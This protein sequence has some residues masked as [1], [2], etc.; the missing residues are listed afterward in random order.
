MRRA[1]TTRPPLLISIIANVAVRYPLEELSLRPSPL[2]AV[3]AAMHPPSIRMLGLSVL[4]STIPALPLVGMRVACGFPSPAD[5]F[6]DEELDLTKR[7][8]TNP[9][10]TF[11]AEAEGDSMVGFGIHPG[12]TLVVDRSITARDGDIA[13]VLWDG[14][15]TVK[16]LRLRRHWVELISGNEQLAPIRVTDGVELQVWGVVTW[17]FRKHW[18]R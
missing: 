7:C 5:D 8:I 15:L 1:R 13:I 2:I 16:Q 18:R 3:L 6:L 4:H 12:D 9:V 14:G 10:A 11:F 17:S